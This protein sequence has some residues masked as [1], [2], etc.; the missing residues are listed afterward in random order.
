M[1]TNNSSA[2]TISRRHFLGTTAL[3]LAAASTRAHAAGD[4]FAFRY[5]VASCM[6]GELPLSEI[7]PEL[8][9]TG[10]TEIDIWPR[11]HGNQRE[12]AEEM[13][14]D[15]FAELLANHSVTLGIST[16][17][18]LGPYKLQDEMKVVSSLGGDMI[19]AGSGN[20]EG[21]TEKE[22]VQ[23]FV[24]KM[25]PHTER[26]EE[27][28]VTIAI[29]NHSSQLL[30]S[31]DSLRYLAE[32]ADSDRLGIAFAPYHL[33]Q[34]PKLLAQLIRDLGPKMVHFYAWEH[35]FGCMEKMPKAQEMQQLPGY[36]SLD[37]GPIVNALR[38]TQYAGRTSIFMHP[39]PRGIPILPTATQVTRAMNRSRQYIESFL[40]ESNG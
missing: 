34:D 24:E 38:E 8:A 40:G 19:V 14:F 12:Q 22:R 37:F 18:D 10:A 25:K 4:P 30:Y 13:G 2:T 35:G 1:S 20:V 27:L 7:V 28:G 23:N 33:P 15:K 32:F 5:I 6:Y 21:A 29:E 31:P 17:Y 9:K 3:T 16:R 26:A 11:V 39:V 36:G